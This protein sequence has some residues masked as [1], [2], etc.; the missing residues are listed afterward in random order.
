MIVSVLFLVVRT[1]NLPATFR[2]HIKWWSELNNEH[3]SYNE[4]GQGEEE[5]WKA[6]KRN[7]REYLYF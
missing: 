2:Y 5:V 3:G 1:N 4:G 7:S 6:F